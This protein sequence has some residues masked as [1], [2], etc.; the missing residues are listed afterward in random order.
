[1]GLDVVCALVMILGF[2]HGYQKGILYSI[3][4]FF[5]VFIASIAAMKLSFWASTQL[6]GVMKIPPF[7]LPIISMTFVFILVFLG[8]RLIGHLL[9][10][11][12]SSLSLTPLNKV[13]GGI[14]WMMMALF[15][16][17]S[18]LW[19]LDKGQ[20][21][22]PSLKSTSITYALLQPIAP[23]VFDIIGFLI[24]LFKEWYQSV[25]GLFD[26]LGKKI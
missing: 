1:M 23:C 2:Y 8:L 3:I 16:L 4:S 17:S 19:L 24:P 20:I 14:L 7:L 26:N 21:L 15:I 25:E 13:S 6:N 12:I 11:F 18:F 9:E 5:G 10:K 22:L